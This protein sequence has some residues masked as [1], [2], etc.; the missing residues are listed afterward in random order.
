MPKGVI[1][2]VVRGQSVHGKNGKGNAH[3]ITGWRDCGRG[4][5]FV[6]CGV[7][8][9]VMTSR[10]QT[11]RSITIT[12]AMNKRASLSSG[13]GWTYP[14][15]CPVGDHHPLFIAP[16]ADAELFGGETADEQDDAEGDVEQVSR[17]AMRPKRVV[18]VVNP[19]AEQGLEEEEDD[20]DEAEELSEASV[21]FS[22]RRDGSGEASKRP[23]CQ[24]PK[25]PREPKE[26]VGSQHAHP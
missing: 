17:W 16:L 10:G 20:D 6:P 13:Q 2:R 3:V 7:V 4:R 19:E 5:R 21:R 26:K 12:E 1:S 23:P 11:I 22:E 24:C 18:P 25:M 15:P 8:G 9:A 14:R